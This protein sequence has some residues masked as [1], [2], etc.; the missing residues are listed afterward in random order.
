MQLVLA[1]YGEGASDERFLPI[2]IERTVQQIV[3]RHGRTAVDVVG[4]FVVPPDE[5]GTSQEEKI[6]AAAKQ[7]QGYHALI[8]HA[9]A[10]STTRKRA[11]TER[12]AP[13]MRRVE[14]AG[15]HLPLVPLIPVRM[16]AMLR[17]LH[18]VY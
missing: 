8:L 4:P 3:A 17:A 2:L 9:D 13:G 5:P 18:L 6:L 10:D 1:F 14:Q 11:L 16:T 15:I 12:I 7:A